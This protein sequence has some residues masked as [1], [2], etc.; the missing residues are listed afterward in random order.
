MIYQYTIYKYIQI[1]LYDAPPVVEK[2]CGL[3]MAVKPKGQVSLDVCMSVCM[4]V[5]MFVCMFVFM[6]LCTYVY[7][8]I[9]IY[10]YA[11]FYAYICM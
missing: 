1:Y 5:C 6:F 7:I 10:I 2:R 11:C 8:N 9:Y 3:E 4:D